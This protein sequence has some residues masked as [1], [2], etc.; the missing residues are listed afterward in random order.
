MQKT[1][2]ELHVPFYDTVI[3]DLRSLYGREKKLCQS[4][5][6]THIKKVNREALEDDAIRRL[7]DQLFIRTTESTLEAATL[8]E[9]WYWRREGRH[10]YF[11][12]PGLLSKLYEMHA[13]IDISD[14]EVPRDAFMMAIPRGE[15]IGGME[16][17]PFLVV[18]KTIEEKEAIATEFGMKMFGKGIQVLNKADT[19]PGDPSMFFT[20]TG[21]ADY[22]VRGGIW[23][24]RCSVPFTRIGPL[25]AKNLDES[26]AMK[27]ILGGYGGEGRSFDLSDEEQRIQHRMMK[28]VVMLSLYMKVF[29]DAIVDGFPESYAAPQCGIRNPTPSTIGS[30]HFGRTGTSPSMHWRNAHFRRYPLRKDGS[31]TEGVVFVSGT[32]VR[33]VTP[34]TINDKENNND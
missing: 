11:P 19:I 30:M 8:V 17:P 3:K 29:P 1:A 9:Y 10:V 4:V 5:F 14:F 18:T 6:G 33:P 22:D 34:H 20:S 16:I 24:Q 15:K 26:V 25:L 27:T 32:V 2:Y 28:C 21:R 31:R 23:T 7:A 13:D 12:V